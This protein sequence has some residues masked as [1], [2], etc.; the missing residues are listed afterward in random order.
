MAGGPYLHTKLLEL[1]CLDG[2][3]GGSVSALPQ[4]AGL[5]KMWWNVMEMY[6]VYQ[7]VMV[8]VFRF[9]YLISMIWHF[10]L[11]LRITYFD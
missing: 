3:G 5:W 11:S 4:D 8:E 7:V 9:H 6:G 10:T 2:G 1:R